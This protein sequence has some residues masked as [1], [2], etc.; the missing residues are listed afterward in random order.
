MKKVITYISV[1]L[2]FLATGLF[3]F[4]NYREIA[5]VYAE[6]SSAYFLWIGIP[7]LIYLAFLVKRTSFIENL[8]H[9]FTHLIFA[10]VCFRR[11]KGF[12]VT[13]SNG[14]MYTESNRYNMV[15]T[16]SP[17]FFP[18]ITGIMILLFSFIPSAISQP[19]VIVSYS[20]FVV[21]TVKS[22][23]K[24]PDEVRSTGLKGYLFLLVMTF[25]MSFLVFTWTVDPGVLCIEFLKSLCYGFIG[26]C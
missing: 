2:M 23:I 18:L 13:G 9:E 21:V 11:I 25:W 16:L 7:V 4:H 10:L 6:V 26:T 15:I 3:L 8:V 5:A 20:L 22:M 12:Y 1:L 24:S 17:Y 19:L 14:M